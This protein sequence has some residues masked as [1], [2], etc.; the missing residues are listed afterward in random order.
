M[1]ERQ[2]PKLHTRVRFPSPA[3]SISNSAL[4]CLLSL[5]AAAGESSPWDES[6]RL[7]DFRSWTLGVERSLLTKPEQTLNVQLSTPNAQ[8]KA[9]SAHHEVQHADRGVPKRRRHLFGGAVIAVARWPN[10]RSACLA[11]VQQHVEW[12]PP[13]NRDTRPR[14][15]VFPEA[16]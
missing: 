14:R 2:L 6:V 12:H 3:L 16:Q 8:F 15:L 10:R 1:V 5:P 9:L 11:R 4:S 7:A 13:Q